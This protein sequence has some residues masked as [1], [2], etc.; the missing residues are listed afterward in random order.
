MTRPLRLLFIGTLVAVMVLSLPLA[1][2]AV[3][4]GGADR[5]LAGDAVAVAFA[6]ALVALLTSGWWPR[7][8]APHRGRD[9][10]LESTVV[11][12]LLTTYSI[13]LTWELGWVLAREA[14]QTAPDAIWSY[15]WWAYIDGGDARYASSDPGFLLIEMLSVA[16]GFAG[17]LALGRWRAVGRPT[18]GVLVTLV[19]SA[20]V[21]LYSAAFYLFGEAMAGYPN[22]DTDSPIDFV[23]KFWALNGIWLVMPWLV[24]AWATRQLR[25]NEVGPAG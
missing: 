22:V 23:I 6:A 5:N 16:N 3:F 11:V 4:A 19:A 12:W 8:E 21:H 25:A 1:G 9:Q 14:I 13:H 2:V 20:A 7:S 10:K 24:I 15:P 18:A 17:M